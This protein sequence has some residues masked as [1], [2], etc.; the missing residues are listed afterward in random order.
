[1]SDKQRTFA[2]SVQQMSMRFLGK[3]VLYVHEAVS[4]ACTGLNYY[5]FFKFLNSWSAVA[6]RTLCLWELQHSFIINTMHGLCG[7]DNPRWK[8]GAGFFSVGSAK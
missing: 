7:V 6:K 1:M 8:T 4:H 3:F 2:L 5:H